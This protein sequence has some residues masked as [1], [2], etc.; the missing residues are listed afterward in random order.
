MEEL[1]LSYDEKVEATLIS[2]RFKRHRNIELYKEELKALLGP[3]SRRND[4]ATVQSYL[5]HGMPLLALRWADVKISEEQR[6][7]IE[8]L[9]IP[10]DLIQV[11]LVDIVR[12]RC[13]VL[14]PVLSKQEL[15]TVFGE[16]FV[17][18]K[19]KLAEPT[20]SQYPYIEMARLLSRSLVHEELELTLPQVK[21]VV[22]SI[23]EARRQGLLDGMGE[24]AL[25]ATSV[26]SVSPDESKSKLTKL[27]QGCLSADQFS[28]LKQLTSQRYVVDSSSHDAALAIHGIEMPAKNTASY[29]EW[30]LRRRLARVEGEA[31][32]RAKM[33]RYM[34]DE[35]SKIIGRP[36]VERICGKSTYFREGYKGKSPIFFSS[37]MKEF[38]ASTKG[39]RSNPRRQRNE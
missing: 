29:E 2:K 32:K 12:A 24:Q 20:M 35:L 34:Q 11:V 25:G 21:K 27:F 38:I 1:G 6:A 36:T 14:E 31:I 26:P 10:E 9:R 3:K 18:S 8:D 39:V 28:R 30:K 33:N 22:E 15:E 37:A 16:P 13:E 7:R 4:E 17:L 5:E 19:L 23:R